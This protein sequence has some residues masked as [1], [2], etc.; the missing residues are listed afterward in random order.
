MKLLKRVQDIYIRKMTNIGEIHFG[1]V[2][3]RVNTDAT[4]I[5][6]QL[7]K[8]SAANKPFFLDLQKALDRVPRKVLWW[9]LRI[10]CRGIGCACQPGYV[11][12]TLMHRVVCGPMVSSVKS[13]EWELVCIKA[14]LSTPVFILVLE[15]L[16][17]EFR[18]GVTWEL[19]CVDDWCSSRTP[20]RNVSPSSMR[21]R[22]AWKVKGPASTCR[23]PSSWSPA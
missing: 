1:F 18:T 2:H 8:Y 20:R 12:C 10:L 17:R 5:V 23:R 15:A 11:L 4:F 14:V 13:L 9:I 7:Q 19:L 6:R 16:L 22:L 3:G 21:G